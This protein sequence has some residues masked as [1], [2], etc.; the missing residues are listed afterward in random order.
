MEIVRKTMQGSPY[1]GVFCCVT[2]KIGL[3][4]FGTS[5]KETKGLKELF[6]VEIIE[7]KLAESALLGIFAS[8]NSNGFVVGEIVSDKE[9]DTL[10]G[11]GLRIK[12]LSGITAIGN[13]LEA[14][15]SKGI[16]S[17]EIKA[18]ARKTIQDFLKIELKETKIAGSDLAGSCIVATNRGFAMNANASE[19]EFAE[20]KKF[21]GF[22]GSLST[23]NYG[24]AF[25]G[26]CIAANTRAAIVGT[27]TSGIEM[28][29]I[30]EGLTGE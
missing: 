25:V 27:H 23:A 20:T 26:N 9:I 7:A 30:D 12:K 13:L 1:V 28:M 17:P 3:F 8:G 10:A 5:A 14:N 6:D 21:F 19:K 24:D 16:C 4:P 2:D 29:H 18:K 15:D 22:E 11:I